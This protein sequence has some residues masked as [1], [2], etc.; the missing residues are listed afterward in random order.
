M[1]IPKFDN[2][3]NEQVELKDGRNVFLSRSVA[4]VVPVSAVNEKGEIYHLI[5]K[6]GIKTPNEQGK[7]NIVCGYLDYNESLENACKRELFEETGLNINDYD[8][9]L[10]F[11]LP[12]RIKSEPTDKVQ[13]VS[14]TFGY[15]ISF[16][17]SEGLPVLTNEY[18]DDG[19]V[20][21]SEWIKEED[22]EKFDFAFNHNNILDKWAEM[23]KGKL[24]YS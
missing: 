1:S 8:V 16:R 12:W 18:A 11:E 5:S 10:D 2:V 3:Q 24:H 17:K 9:W 19:E 20:E 14:M 23:I 22:F 7:F 4:V 6:R 15:M 21:F 13:N